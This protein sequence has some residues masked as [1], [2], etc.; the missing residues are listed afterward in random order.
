MQNLNPHVKWFKKGKIKTIYICFVLVC[1]LNGYG[2]VQPNPLNYGL[3]FVGDAARA[4]A[5][6]RSVIEEFKK[7]AQHPLRM[8]NGRME[9]ILGPD[10]D[11]FIASGVPS[12]Q[13]YAPNWQMFSGEVFLTRPDGVEIYGTY[14]LSFEHKNYLLIHYPTPVADGDRIEGIAKENGIFVTNAESIHRIDYGTF[15]VAPPRVIPRPLTAEQITEAQNALGKKKAALAAKA[16]AQ[17]QEGA[18]RGDSYDEFRM[19]Q[20]YRDGDGV[21]KDLRKARELFGKSAAQGVKD[22]S[23]ALAQLVDK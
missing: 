23:T 14:G 20:R 4:Q 21:A 10:W 16:L 9:K 19:G 15:P 11:D 5:D 12:G 3:H 18:A 1:A 8:V 7:M 22:A 17:N 2:Q 13:I 6:Q